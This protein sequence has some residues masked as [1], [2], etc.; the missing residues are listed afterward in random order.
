MRCTH[1]IAVGALLLAGEVLADDEDIRDIRGAKFMNEDWFLPAAAAVLLLLALALYAV[2]RWRRR[3][4]HER[5]LLPF[6]LALQR[7]DEIRSMMIAGRAREFCSAASDVVRGY[8]EQ[9]FAVIVT[10]RT[11]EEFLSE[12]LDTNDAKLAGHRSSLAEFLQRCDLV[13]FAGISIATSD[14]ESLRQS[15]RTFVLDTSKTEDVRDPVPA[16]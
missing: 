2:W 9:R 16:A 13:K 12:L 3:R 6:E 4:R 11:T 15:A 7:L 1:G 10:Q 8:I 5:T 14:M